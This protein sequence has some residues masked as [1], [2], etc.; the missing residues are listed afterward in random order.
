MRILVTRLL[1]VLDFIHVLS[2]SYRRLIKNV[3]TFELM[4]FP[5]NTCEI[6][7]DKIALSAV[8]TTNFL[9][10]INHEQDNVELTVLT[11]CSSDKHKP[12]VSGM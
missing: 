9:N 3:E 2:P 6:W 1:I 12:L 4:F 11:V 10:S 8:H 5:C 7:Y